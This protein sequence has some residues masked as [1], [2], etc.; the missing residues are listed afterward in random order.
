MARTKKQK[1]V[2]LE[3]YKDLIKKSKGVILVKTNRV[4]PNEVSAF[5][6]EL[7]DFDS[8][9][10]VV[11][12]TLF[13]IALNENGIEPMES[14][15]FQSHSALFFGEDIVGP[16][17]AL[18]KFVE[19]TTDKS[20]ESA[21]VQ[22]VGGVLDGNVLSI[23]QVKDLADM[24]SKEQSISMILGILD[25]AVA[26]VLNVLQNPVQSYASILDQAFKE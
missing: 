7:F 8:E 19:D 18:K 10:H 3:S 1:K 11:K 5:K 16:A 22:I 2:I 25:Q 24:P 21:K 13:K 14:L 23:Q 20:E 9:F 4:T 26:G 6:K 15:D 12:N 17:K